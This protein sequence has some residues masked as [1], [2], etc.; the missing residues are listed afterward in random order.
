[1]TTFEHAM[2]GLNGTLAAGL[3]RKYGWQIAALAAAAAVV[4]DWDGLTLLCGAGWFARAHRAWGHNVFLAASLG[5]ALAAADYRFDLL[6]RVQIAA[7]GRWP[8]LLPPAGSIR[9]RTQRSLGGYATW[10]LV[11]M[12][13]SLSHLAADLVFSGGRTLADWQLQLLWP[14]S[15]RGFV[16]PLVPWGDAGVTL[17][18]V[19]GMFALWRWPSRVELVAR[20]TLAAAVAF[21]ACR[22]LL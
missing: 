3:Q 7:A 2:L 10:T 4:P 14:C 13:G 18:F 1:M 12:L 19:A 6:T 16:Y 20:M 21:I 5:A 17:V 22:G 9:R 8:R 15:S 11:G